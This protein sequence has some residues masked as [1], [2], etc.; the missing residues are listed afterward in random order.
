MKRLD[1]L[2]RLAQLQSFRG[3]LMI[4]FCLGIV[5]VGPYLTLGQQPPTPKPAQPTQ[6]PPPSRSA[7][8]P[9]PGA[10]P[11]PTPSV[12]PTPFVGPSLPGP[13]PAPS[14]SPSP[15]VSASP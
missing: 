6:T 11:Q 13:L 9:Q 5:F 4:W 8:S 10:S 1:C 12:Q 2:S 3:S 7:P 15:A 14:S